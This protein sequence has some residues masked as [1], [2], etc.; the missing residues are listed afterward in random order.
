MAGIQQ[1][2]IGSLYGALGDFESI[3]TVTVGAG[4]S[5]TVDFTSI[6]A[7]Y[8]HL[9]IRGIAKLSGTTTP[10][11]FY[12]HVGNGSIDTGTN[13]SGHS[14]DGNGATVVADSS[15]SASSIPAGRIATSS[16]GTNANAFGIF[17][18]DFLDYANT[19]KYKTVR[20]LSG[21]DS[22]GTGNAI[23]SSGNW[24]STSAIDSIRFFGSGEDLTQYSHF[25]LYGIKG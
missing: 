22:N 21:W 5:A 1:G 16:A 18:I 10:R 24:R 12:M 14:L 23:L 17:V 2:L 3:A 15:V 4:G 13:Y 19:S 6:P 11:F 25:A 9:Q 20:S 7:T 8:T